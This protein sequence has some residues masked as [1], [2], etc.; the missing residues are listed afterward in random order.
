MAL[1]RSESMKRAWI[2]RRTTA[3]KLAAWQERPTCLCCGALLVRA[4]AKLSFAKSASVKTQRLFKQGHDARLK[5]LAAQVVRGEAPASR[6]PVIARLMRNRIGF[7][8]TRPELMPA[9]T[10]IG[11]PRKRPNAAK[12]A[13]V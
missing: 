2:A 9:F 12:Q 11:L 5:A 4:S 13:E 10:G 7:L 6:I 3:Q 8:K 1:N